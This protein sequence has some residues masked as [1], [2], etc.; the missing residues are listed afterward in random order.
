MNDDGTAGR[1]GG[2][3]EITAAPTGFF[4]TERIDGAW[5]LISP[6]GFG[7]ITVG[8]NHL[9]DTD[10]RYP[11]NFDIWQRR[12]GSRARWIEAAT[13][14][15]RRWGFNT[16]GWT[17]Q[18]VSARHHHDIDW[19][20]PLNLGHGKEW[21]SDELRCTGMPYVQQLSVA[22]IEG[23]NGNPRWPDVFS[24]EFDEHC[25][26]LAREYCSRVADDP[27]LIGYFLTD[28]PSWLPHASGGNFVGLD[29]PV[30]QGH[31]RDLATIAGQ[32]YSTISRHI[33]AY[34]PNHLILGDRYN[35]NMGIPTEVLHAAAPYIDV[36]S[37]QYFAGNDGA[38]CAAMRDDLAG[39]SAEVDLPV[40]VADI[41]NCAPTS[42][43]SDRD[44]GLSDHADRGRHYVEAFDS[45]VA[46]PWLIGW[47]WCS[48]LE[49]TARG[50]GLKDGYD[51][52]YTDLTDPITAFNHA[53]YQRRS[54]R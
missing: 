21:S 22:E 37:V 31:S 53:V 20:T 23:W 28:I 34:D 27:Q 51:N 17:R 14:D 41:G 19:V 49:N 47:H 54:N 35:G 45:I 24:S 8:L 18:W 5:W 43:N 6:D 25:A 38:G 12:Y 46:E 44:C 48:Y 26:W 33:R 50:W 13:T 16:I 52:A 36:L 15:L 32:Y 7:F 2:C 4:R 29:G 3:A 10:L 39:W 9:D 1:F 40:I 30:P 42:L 11:H